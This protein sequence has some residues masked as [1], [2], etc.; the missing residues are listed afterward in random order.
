MAKQKHKSPCYGHNGNMLFHW[1][2]D[3]SWGD[4]PMTVVRDLKRMTPRVVRMFEVGDLPREGTKWKLKASSF[5]KKLCGRN[6]TR[7]PVA[8]IKT[9][10]SSCPH[11]CGLHPSKWMNPGEE[12]HHPETPVDWDTMDAIDAACQKH[13]A[14]GYTHTRGADAMRSQELKNVTVN[15]SCDNAEELA[16]YYRKGCETVVIVSDDK[17]GKTF[18][19]NGVPVVM[20]PAQTNEAAGVTCAGT[21]ACGGDGAPLCARRNRGFAIGFFIHSARKRAANEQMDLVQIGEKRTDLF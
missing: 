9:S 3:P 19:V 17:K 13:T 7:G 2:D 6:S 5:N 4:G 11:S 14:F 18:N 15:I 8:A 1:K 20:C 16:E 10:M 21:R 12:W